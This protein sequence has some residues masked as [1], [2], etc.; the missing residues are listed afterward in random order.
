MENKES[1]CS[2]EQSLQLVDKPQF[3]VR[4]NWGFFC[5]MGKQGI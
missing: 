2:A 5:K 3:C 4:Q 1:D